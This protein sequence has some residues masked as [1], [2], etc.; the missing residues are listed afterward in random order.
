MVIVH[1]IKE[2]A[3][4]KKIVSKVSITAIRTT[5]LNAVYQWSPQILWTHH[6][7]LNHWVYWWSL[8]ITFCSDGKWSN[9]NSSPLLLLPLVSLVLAFLHI[10]QKHSKVLAVVTEERYIIVAFTR[11]RFHISYGGV[12]LSRKSVFLSC[13]SVI[14]GHAGGCRVLRKHLLNVHLY[15]RKGMTPLPKIYISLCLLTLILQ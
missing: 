12:F 1:S 15:S 3:F 8:R 4:I 14:S 10:G 9:P 7:G 6:L 13:K 11:G 2:F 5:W